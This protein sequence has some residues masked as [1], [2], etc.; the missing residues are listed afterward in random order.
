VGQDIEREC[1]DAGDYERFEERL[2]EC[3]VV[4]RELL[5]RPGF[6]EGE[7]TIGAELELDLVDA[8]L[9][10]PALLNREVLA[11][12]RDPLLTVELD[13]FN[14]EINTAPLRLQGTPFSALAQTLGEKLRRIRSAAAEHAARAVTIGILPTLVPGDLEGP[15]VTE[16]PRYRA[17]CAGIEGRR[18][19]PRPLYIEGDESLALPSAEV[20]LAGANTSFQVHLKVAPRDF[21]RIYNAAQ[22]ASAPAIALA[23]NSP[24]LFGRHLWEETRLALFRAAFDERPASGEDW[25]APRVSFGYGWGRTSPLELFTEAVRLHEPL[26]PIVSGESPVL[27]AA[28]GGVPALDELRLHSGTVWHWNRP[29]YDRALGGHLRL[30]LR[31][32]PSG[33]TVADMVAN[34]A[35]LLGLTLGL[36][37]EVNSMMCAL[38]FLNA[39]RNFYRA[40]CQGLDAELVWPS[41]VDHRVRPVR[42]AAVCA[43]VLCVARKGLVDGGVLEREAD[44]WLGVV[45]ERISRAMTGARWQMHAFDALR[46]RS[47][48]EEASQVM[49]RRYID[50]SD[51][52]QPVHGW[53]T[54]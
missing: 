13:R 44:L 6:G 41:P 15:I 47:S 20:A 33:P 43:E 48:S 34:A 25:R 14:L 45:E 28:D 52:E 3:L 36:A 19:K 38:T 29:V 4:L 9:M 31:A 21:C 11:S 30:E 2:D 35:F 8:A 49:L 22:I 42:A 1:F 24:L 16:R 53:P 5:N 39:R 26:L 51:T 50:L 7:P 18:C 27:A 37:H 46:A 32:L 12:A 54:L 10:R 17:L 23:G 40:A